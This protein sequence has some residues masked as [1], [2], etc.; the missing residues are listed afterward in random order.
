MVLDCANVPA[1]TALFSQRP[2]DLWRFDGGD[3]RP[4]ASPEYRPAKA[5]WR[6]LSAL[7]FNVWFGEVAL[8]R[9]ARA[10]LSILE[11]RAPTFVALQEVTARFLAVLT[12]SAFVRERYGL[13]DADGS[14]FDEY[15]TVLLSSLLPSRLWLA[16]LGGSMGRSM[17]WA[18][19]SLPDSTL[20]VGA[21]HLESGRHNRETRAEQLAECAARLSGA[22]AALLM[23]DCNF[24]DGDALEER[25]LSAA[26]LS[27]AWRA[28]RPR[29]PGY[30]RDTA[31][32]AMA[33]SMRDGVVQRR[34][35]RVF[36]RGAAVRPA[37]IELVGQDPIDGDAKLFASD[38]FGVACEFAR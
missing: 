21:A 4:V 8:E 30:T 36:V 26:G 27:D 18:E 11:A 22:D 15:G 34:I 5:Q 10:V 13:S 29:D 1:V 19:F 17:P 2:L 25:A 7:T 37:R 6:P 14:T 23:G 32:N 33:A 3:W 16:E 20:S 35:D 31:R 28:L 38:H 12:E 24:A 9:R